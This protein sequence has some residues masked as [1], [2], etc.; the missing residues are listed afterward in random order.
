MRD[1]QNECDSGNIMNGRIMMVCEAFGGGVY[2]YVSQLC[3]DMAKDF[4]VSLV[5]SLRTQ[6]PI[7]F[8]DCIDDRVQLVQ[9]DC[10]SDRSPSGIC[11]SVREL[12]R[13]KREIRPDII[14][15]H[16]SIAGGLGRLAFDGSDCEVVYTPHGY[17]HVLMGP[18]F[19]SHLYRLLEKRLGKCDCMTLTCCESEDEEARS[20]S[21]RTA[22]IET[23]IDV[24]RF[25]QQLDRVEPRSY[26][27][28][29]VFTLGRASEQKRPALFNQIAELV[30]DADFIWVGGGELEGKLTAPNLS[31]TG[32]MPRFDALSIAEGADVFVLCSYGEAIAMSV[33]ESMYMKK[34]CLVSNTM[35]NRSVIQNGINGYVCDTAADYAS[36]IQSAMNCFPTELTERANQDVLNK[37]NSKIMNRK[38]YEVYKNLIIN[39]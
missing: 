7:N 30:P 32:W 24:D 20:F 18:S 4:D 2:A 13:I 21:K 25:A 36:R 31:I 17:A 12:R 26:K 14:H 19:K 1:K 35:G 15:L 5:F 28:F 29:T 8:R 6:T 27:R 16:S 10:M 22:I 37:Y 38:Y 3:N 33:L 39:H 11:K 34:L 9:L 23:G